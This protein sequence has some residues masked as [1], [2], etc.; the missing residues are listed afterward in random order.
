M[1]SL[2]AKK[3]AKNNHKVWVI[4]NRIKGK[5]YKDEK[6]IQ[7]FFVPPTLEY[8]GGL[9]PSFLDNLGYSISTII[10]GLKIIKKEKIDLIL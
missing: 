6:N 8:K 5:Q 1:F 3:L 10:K 2:I 9:P 4:T 7:L